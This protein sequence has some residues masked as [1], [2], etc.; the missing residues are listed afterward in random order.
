MKDV[1]TLVHQAFDQVPPD[2]WENCCTHCDEEVD[3]AW[4]ADGIQEE[5]VEPVI[6]KLGAGDGDDEEDDEL[7]AEAEPDAEDIVEYEEV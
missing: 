1:E 4:E 3:K 5:I 7:D 2:L 6:I